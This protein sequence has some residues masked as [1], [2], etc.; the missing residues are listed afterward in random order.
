MKNIYQRYRFPGRY[1]IRVRKTPEFYLL[2]RQRDKLNL[3]RGSMFL[4]QHAVSQS[5]KVLLEDDAI[6]SSVKHWLETFVVEQNLC[7]FAKRELA[8]GR[9]RFAV[10]PAF[11]EEQLLL[12]LHDELELLNTDTS[13]ETTLL[14]HP[15]VLQRFSDYNQ[16]LSAA[17]GFLVQS[18]LEGTYQIAS[19]HPDYQFAGTDPDDAENYSNRAPYPLLHILREESVDRAVRAYPDIEQIPARNIELLNRLGKSKLQALWQ[20]CFN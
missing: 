8:E 15:G 6:V 14:I 5:R 10:T 19:F 17:E 7:P 12:A 2:D 3:L 11:T 13:V 1:N 18:E 9:V 20:A 16:F 4:F